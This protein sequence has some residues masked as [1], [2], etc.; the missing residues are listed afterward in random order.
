M[1]LF[2][3]VLRIVNSIDLFINLWFSL[4]FSILHRAEREPPK[5]IRTLYRA[6]VSITDRRK[7]NLWDK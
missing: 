3:D 7:H 2:V 1:L 6:A 5:L 4:N